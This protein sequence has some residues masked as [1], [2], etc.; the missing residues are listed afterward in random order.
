[1]SFLNA[2]TDLKAPLAK[3]RRGTLG[4]GISPVKKISRTYTRYVQMMKLLLPLVAV[5]LLIMIIIW[6]HLHGESR[7]FS[8]GFSNIEISD[9]KDPSMINAR[10]VGTDNDN[11]PFAITADIAKKTDD[12]TQS[13][14]LELPK[15]DL[16]LQDG[17]W[18]VL[19]AQTG[20][21][22]R[23]TQYLEL[24]GDVNVFHDSGYEMHTESAAI[25]LANGS[26]QGY[27]EVIGQGPF[28]QINAEGFRL[29]DK[30]RTIVFTG[31]TSA[32]LYLDR[33]NEQP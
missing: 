8:I 24:E 32:T 9:A 26:A 6:P 15:A 10:Y 11:Q 23:P 7:Q 21:Y 28:G 33:I 29:I 1:M 25:D 14:L 22:D 19:T 3:G 17:S 13:I 31:K 20:L 30:G 16:T 18:V 2:Q 5:I 27:S 4:G 12:I